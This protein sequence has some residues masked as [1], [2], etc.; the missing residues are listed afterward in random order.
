MKE[1]Y[2][3]VYLDPRK[4]GKFTYDGLDVSFLFEPF[5]IGKGFKKRYH[6]HL[7]TALKNKKSFNNILTN[8]IKK[9]LSENLNPFIEKIKIELDEKSSYKFEKEIIKIIGKKINNTGSL[10][11]ILDGGKDDS[12]FKMIE[13]R[14]INSL[15]I[16]EKISIAKTGVLF[17]KEHKKSLSEAALKKYQNGFIQ[18]NKGKSLSENHKK[19]LRK[20]KT[21]PN[22]INQN[23]GKTLEEKYGLEKAI[24]LKNNLK[25]NVI[26]YYKNNTHSQ[27]GKTYEDMYGVEEA[28]IRK[29]KLKEAQSARKLSVLTRSRISDKMK[30]KVIIDEIVY[31]SL[32]DAVLK[33]SGCYKTMITRL[34]SDEYPNYNYFKN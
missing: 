3:Y 2:V 12:V 29:N 7:T 14:R 25:N 21:F 23:K 26:E 10:L 11:N 34:K 17:S 27:K 9:I 5:Y 31:N 16:N 6:S 32:A 19:A 22:N 15:S 4:P 18:Y 1:Y 24:E 28:K 33:L 13:K 30:K 8:K 20:K